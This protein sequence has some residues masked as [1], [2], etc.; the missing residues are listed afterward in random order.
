LLVAVSASIGTVGTRAHHRRLP[1]RRPRCPTHPRQ[2][3]RSVLRRF[4]W[5][6]RGSSLSVVPDAK[7]TGT[8]TNF[9]AANI[10][11]TDHGAEGGRGRQ[12]V[13]RGVP[14]VIAG[15]SIGVRRAASPC[16][17]TASCR[18]PIV[19]PLDPY[20]RPGQGRRVG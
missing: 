1:D 4:Q 5:P 10:A 9:T 8:S 15:P 2:R 18:R 12:S 14:A 19:A 3:D 7:S 16:C 17:S 13:E 6:T 20:A 11:A